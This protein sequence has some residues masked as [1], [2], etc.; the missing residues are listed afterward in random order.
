[1]R[2]RAFFLGLICTLLGFVL[3]AGMLWIGRSVPAYP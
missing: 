2:R 1:M 3:L